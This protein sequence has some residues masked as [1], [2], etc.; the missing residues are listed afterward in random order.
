MTLNILLVDDEALARSR[1]QTL[2]DDCLPTGGHV[3]LQ[4]THA[5][6]AMEVFRSNAIDLAFL[7]VRMPGLDGI[8]LARAI[9]QLPSPPAIVFVTGHESHAAQAFDLEAVDFLTK[10][11]RP[12]RLQQA[13]EKARRHLEAQ[14]AQVEQEVASQERDLVILDRGR[15]QRVSIADVLYLKAELK[16]VTVRTSSRSHILD[17]S[18]SDLE[19]RYSSRFIRV[20]RNALIARRALRSLER[21]TDP[22]DGICWAVRVAGLDELLVVS[23][24]QLSAVRAALVS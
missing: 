16:Y 22:V 4:A 6:Q 19:S 20:H 18:L 8:G 2:L 21:T 15:T 7:D 24:R 10:P 9:G 23:R 13:L 12:E 5:V 1:M 17:G 11:V 3:T 14:T